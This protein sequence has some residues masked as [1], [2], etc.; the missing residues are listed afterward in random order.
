MTDKTLQERLRD[1]DDTF[2]SIEPDPMNGDDLLIVAA[3]ALDAKDAE[4]ARLRKA[5]ERAENARINAEG[6]QDAPGRIPDCD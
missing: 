6:W 5:L 4:I 1:L 3:A 2:L